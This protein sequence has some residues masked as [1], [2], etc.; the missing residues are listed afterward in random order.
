[1]SHFKKMKLVPFNTPPLQQPS[2]KPLTL[3]TEVA[4]EKNINEKNE[5]LSSDKTKKLANVDT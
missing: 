2:I 3:P 5:I 4:L 1:M